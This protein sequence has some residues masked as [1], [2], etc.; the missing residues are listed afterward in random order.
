MIVQIIP[1]QSQNI[2]AEQASLNYLF[3]SSYKNQSLS[4]SRLNNINI[5][6]FLPKY[7]DGIELNYNIDSDYIQV[8]DSLETIS[9]R[10]SESYE[11]IE[12]YRAKIIKEPSVWKQNIEFTLQI[13]YELDQVTYEDKLQGQIV[14]TI[15]DDFLG[16]TIYTLIRY[17]QMFFEGALKTIVLALIGTLV[18]FVLA[19]ILAIMKLQKADTH[20]KK[21][22]KILKEI[23]NK[24]ASLYITLFRGTPMIVQASFFWYGFGLFGDPY[25]CGLFVVSLNTAA[26]IAEI[27]RGGIQSIDKGQS[28]A[29][30]AFG[31]N[32]LQTMVYVIFPQAIKNSL[33]AIGNEFIVN[34]K[35]T[36]VLSVIGIFE[37]FNQGRKITGMHYRQLEVYLIVALIYLFLTYTISQVLKHVEIKMNLQPLEITSSN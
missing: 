8:Q 15:P 27:L 9:L 3:Y 7:I 28:E 36:A 10:T 11:N 12:V 34:I 17:G 13:S 35:D 22:M 37:L 19:L 18:G 1:R 33:P 26:Y 4:P 31:M 5:D 24:F 16:G 2:Q 29:A 6:F 23:S 14:K 21:I 32:H 30:Y 20:D 25:Y